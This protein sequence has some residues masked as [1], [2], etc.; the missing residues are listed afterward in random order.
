MK[1]LFIVGAGGFGK[2]VLWQAKRMNKENLEWN[3]K[4]FIDD[5]E[6]LVGTKQ[7]DLEV[8]GNCDYLKTLENDVY[9]VV[10]LGSVR[11]RHIVVDKIKQFPHIHF[12]NIIDPSV[13]MSDRVKNW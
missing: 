11:A 6:S 8:V 2:E 3:I 4:G 7:D 10:A 9:V 13:I 12:A 1:D 5:D